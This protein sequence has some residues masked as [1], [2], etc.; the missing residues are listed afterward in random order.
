MEVLEGRRTTEEGRSERGEAK[1]RGKLG[2]MGRE[3][4]RKGDGGKERVWERQ[5]HVET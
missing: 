5:W 1:E 3:C 4:T 2:Q